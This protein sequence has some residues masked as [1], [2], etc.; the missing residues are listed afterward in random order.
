MYYVYFFES[1]NKNEKDRGIQTYGNKLEVI[2]FIYSRKEIRKK[3]FNIH[4]YL[5][6]KGEQVHIKMHIT[7]KEEKGE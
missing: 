6:I 3:L 5:V 7:I 4:E 1:N 2:Q